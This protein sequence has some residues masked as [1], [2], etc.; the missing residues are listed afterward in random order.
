MTELLWQTM[1]SM[2]DTGLA[3]ERRVAR[4]EGAHAGRIYHYLSI[5]ISIYLQWIIQILS[6]ACCHEILC[7]I[8]IVRVQPQERLLR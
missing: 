1:A 6:L 3:F 7:R 4:V 5:Y 2:R 8:R